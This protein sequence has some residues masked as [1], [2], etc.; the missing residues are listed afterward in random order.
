MNLQPAN[1][2]RKW[3]SKL[4]HKGI[5]ILVR[6]SPQTTARTVILDGAIGRSLCM[7]KGQ[8]FQ[9]LAPKL[10]AVRDE[11]LHCIELW[12]KNT[13]VPNPKGRVP[14]ISL[15]CTADIY[16]GLNLHRRSFLSLEPR[17]SSTGHRRAHLVCP[18]YAPSRTLDLHHEGCSH[19]GHAKTS[20]LSLSYNLTEAQ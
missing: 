2:H 6:P 9:L 16:C 14:Y 5:E 7:V 18:E 19:G 13:R 17:S 11:Q 3:P 1:Q 10:T 8:T 20:T 12:Q 4:L 15:Y